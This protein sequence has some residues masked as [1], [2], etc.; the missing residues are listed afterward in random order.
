MRSLLSILYG[1]EERKISDQPVVTPPE[2]FSVKWVVHRYETLP[3]E[4]EKDV[5][6]NLNK[7]VESCPEANFRHATQIPQHTT[8]R[9]S[10]VR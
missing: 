4:V 7:L 2:H 5:L 10:R 8:R 3:V 6:Q 1:A 9:L